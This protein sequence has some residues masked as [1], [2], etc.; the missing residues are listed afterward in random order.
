ME[1]KDAFTYEIRVEEH[2]SEHW[3]EWL[4]GMRSHYGPWAETILIG[5][6]QDQARL[7]GVLIK[8]RNLGLTL[9]SVR[10]IEKKEHRKI[11]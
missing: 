6:L 5:V 4:E 3:S 10:R 7:Y 9:V 2:L 8:I 1:S 11:P